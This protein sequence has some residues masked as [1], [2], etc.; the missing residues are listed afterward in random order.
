MI[1]VHDH[2][3]AKALH[4]ITRLVDEGRYARV[5]HVECLGKDKQKLIVPH[6][7]FIKAMQPYGDGT[8]KLFLLNDHEVLFVTPY[9][10]MNQYS[11]LHLALVEKTGAEE[12]CATLYETLGENGAQLK[13]ILLKA[14]ARD[15]QKLQEEAM[16]SAPSKPVV[17]P[18][19]TP[20]D[21]LVS[22]IQQRR[23][24]N[25]KFTALVIEDDSFSARMVKNLLNKK[26]QVH[27]AEDGAH[28]IR[29]AAMHAPHLILLDINMP[30]MNGL[31]VL[32]KLKEIDPNAYVVMLSGNGDRANVMESMQRGAAGFIGKPFTQEK[33]FHYS[34]A[35]IGNMKINELF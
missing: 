31:E 34:D 15:K 22:T 26:G 24:A 9:L 14:A 1:I 32:E 35:A 16:K 27:L 23:V 21:E 11:Q 20:S 10:S 4:N 33:L 8:S 12:P 25:K 6:E 30:G 7:H 18:L 19:L 5:M 17:A 28:G 29:M 3:L 13:Q 2:A